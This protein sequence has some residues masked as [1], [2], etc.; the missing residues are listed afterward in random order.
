[1]NKSDLT[2]R[3]TAQ[4]SMY[5]ADAAA[6]VNALFY[7]IADALAGGETVTIAGFGTF[8]TKT[9]PA[10]QGPNPR[11]GER[12]AIAASNRPSF[13]AGNTLRDAVN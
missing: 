8:S 2:V 7:T 13:K 10:R 12:I 1:M 3:V 11:T 9:R 4:A 6:A 5:R